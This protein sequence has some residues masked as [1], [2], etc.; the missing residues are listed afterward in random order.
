MT[1]FR[2]KSAFQIMKYIDS[3]LEKFPRPP[4]CH[5]WD[6]FWDFSRMSIPKDSIF[7]Y[8]RLKMGSSRFIGNYISI[9]TSTVFTLGV[10][11]NR[12]FFMPL[13]I[14]PVIWIVICIATE[15]ENYNYNNKKEK[16]YIIP[17]NQRL[18]LFVALSHLVLIV[19]K[20]LKQMYL[21]FCFELFFIVLHSAFRSI[22]REL[23]KPR[24]KIVASDGFID[25]IDND[26]GEEEVTLIFTKEDDSNATLK[27][28]TSQSNFR[29]VT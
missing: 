20:F 22:P 23:V 3:L 10:F 26:E 29:G 21:V 9:Y 1:K 28:R 5:K 14:L 25:E 7:F 2:K 15:V 8:G 12:Y 27:H 6:D 13:L 17:F 16:E 19:T 11:T 18:L 4:T 24:T